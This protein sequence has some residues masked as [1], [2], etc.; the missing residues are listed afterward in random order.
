VDQVLP[1]GMWLNDINNPIKIAMLHQVLEVWKDVSSIHLQPY[2]DDA[3]SWSVELKVRPHLNGFTK[4][5][6]KPKL[7]VFLWRQSENR[8]FLNVVKLMSSCSPK[9]EYGRYIGQARSTTY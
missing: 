8:G 3:W 1:N 5:I 9:E 4:H 7:A 2:E 6:S